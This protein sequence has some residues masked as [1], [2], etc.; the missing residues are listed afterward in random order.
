MDRVLGRWD[1]A[2]HT[3]HIYENAVRHHLTFKRFLYHRN[4]K[5]PCKHVDFLRPDLE[6]PFWSS[7]FWQ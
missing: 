7:D 4:P 5:K 1:N 2:L 6:P 3:L